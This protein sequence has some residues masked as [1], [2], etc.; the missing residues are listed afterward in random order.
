LQTY[1]VA[2]SKT[3]TGSGTL[4]ST[5]TGLTCGTSCSASYP[6]G[7]VLTLAATPAADSTFAGWNGGGCSGTD[8]CTVTLT[9]ATAVTA[10]FTL[11]TYTVALSKTGTGSGTLTSTPTGLTCG[12]SCSASYPSGT[13]LTLAA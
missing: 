3:G 10:T 1:T 11:Q 4:T 12:T 5:P 13:V 7:T 6:S 9:A 8:P 2:L